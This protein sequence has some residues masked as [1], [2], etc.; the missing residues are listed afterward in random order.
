VREVG[1]PLLNE[2]VECSPRYVQR[3]QPTPQETNLSNPGGPP[4]PAFAVKGCWDLLEQELKRGPYS[5]LE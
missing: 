5:E 1:L 3:L 2:G 4:A